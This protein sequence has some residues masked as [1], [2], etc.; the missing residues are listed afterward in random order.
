M[1]SVPGMGEIVR[2]IQLRFQCIELC[3]WHSKKS[4]AL[5]T[6]YLGDRHV[7]FAAYSG[8][9][10]HV[11]R[12]KHSHFYSGHDGVCF[13]VLMCGLIHGYTWYLFGP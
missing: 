6:R 11:I 7:K 1:D 3:R 2:D 8:N 12:G 10:F 5:G 13:V 9:F 4:K